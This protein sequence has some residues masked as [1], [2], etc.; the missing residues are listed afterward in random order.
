MA[1]ISSTPSPRSAPYHSPNTAPARE[2][3]AASFRPSATDGHDAG[4][5]T[6]Q[7]RRNRL[8][9]S[10]PATS[11]TD[12]EAAP[13][14]TDVDTNTKKN[15]AIAAT[16]TGPR[17]R[18]ST[19]NRHGATATHGRGVGDR[20]QADDEPPQP[21]HAGRH[22]SGAEGQQP[23]DGEPAAGRPHRRAGRAEV[24]I[25]AV[26]DDRGDG[27][28][29]CHDHPARPSGTTAP[30]PHGED[31]RQS[32]HRGGD[33]PQVVNR[34]RRSWQRPTPWRSVLPVFHNQ[35]PHII[36][37]DAGDRRMPPEWSRT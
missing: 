31:Q 34:Q 25:A 27:V 5:W 15:T 12:V 3:G 4:S 14:P 2:A 19:I 10:A 20:R 32:G 33:H 37:A 22:E 13:R 16:A 29:G 8:A 26:A 36:V 28:D 23:A 7:T 17:S 1:V 30:H 18:P 24:D 6:D 11:W 9:P 21:R 35:P